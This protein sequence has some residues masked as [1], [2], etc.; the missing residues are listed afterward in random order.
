MTHSIEDV[1][2]FIASLKTDDANKQKFLQKFWEIFVVDTL[3]G[4]VDRH[5]GNWGFL[6]DREDNYQFAPVYD[7]GS[8]LAPLD[9]DKE[10]A[11]LLQDE[12]ELKNRAYNLYPVYTLNNQKIPYHEFYRCNIDELNKAV[13][14]LVPRMNMDE[15]DRIIDNTEALTDVRKEFMKK[16]I[17]M[18]YEMILLP[19]WH[20]SI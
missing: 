19:A 6:I 5:L 18:R 15:I 9:S 13:V 12:T 8:T 10:L 2:Y 4:N 1:E 3:L 14:K 16:S 11:E 17:R 7:C 20:K